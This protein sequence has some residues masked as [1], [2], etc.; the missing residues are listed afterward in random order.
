MSFKKTCAHTKQNTV[1][2]KKEDA[3]SATVKFS[4]FSAELF[5]QNCLIYNSVSV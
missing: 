3:I 1:L 5:N 4:F 2:R